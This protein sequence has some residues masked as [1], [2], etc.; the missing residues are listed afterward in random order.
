VSETGE[1]VERLNRLLKTVSRV[2]GLDFEVEESGNH[3]IFI[4]YDGEPITLDG[5]EIIAMSPQEIADKAIGEFPARAFRAG[6]IAKYQEIERARS[7]PRLR[8]SEWLRRF[9]SSFWA[10]RNGRLIPMVGS[11]SPTPTMD[12]ILLS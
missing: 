1:I 9:E 4:D 10:M 8:K 3:L 2:I 11:G 5:E 12:L 7:E 6:M